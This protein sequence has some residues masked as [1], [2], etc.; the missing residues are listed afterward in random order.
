MELPNRRTLASATDR[1]AELR[2][3]VLAR[4]DDGRVSERMGRPLP[5]EPPTATRGCVR[6]E[7]QEGP[8]LNASVAVL[9]DLEQTHGRTQAAGKQICKKVGAS[10]CLDYLEV[11]EAVGR[12]LH[13]PCISERLEAGR[14]G[15]NLLHGKG[16]GKQRQRGKKEN[17]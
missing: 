1:L 5:H 3:G 16:P 12:Q 8:V 14:L 6:E 10:A 17:R 11:H 13:L 9:E 15:E 2:D 7:P 4:D